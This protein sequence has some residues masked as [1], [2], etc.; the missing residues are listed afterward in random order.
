MKGAI[1]GDSIA[2]A[3]RYRRNKDEDL[4][5]VT[6]P[7]LS[8]MIEGQFVLRFALYTIEIEMPGIEGSLIA[9]V[10]SKQ[11][12]VYSKAS[13]PGNLGIGDLSSVN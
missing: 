13:Y 4:I 8:V 7:D 11:F 3:I 10:Y 5:I 6:F 1:F 12:S 2:S 9:S